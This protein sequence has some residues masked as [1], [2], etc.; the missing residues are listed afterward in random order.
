MIIRFLLRLYDMR[1][2]PKQPPSGEDEKLGGN[3][4]K[5]DQTPKQRGDRGVTWLRG[6]ERDAE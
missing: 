4:K 2:L 1:K 5:D 6:G 3:K